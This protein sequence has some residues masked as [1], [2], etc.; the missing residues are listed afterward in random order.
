MNPDQLPPA[1]ARYVKD[2]A[3]CLV[4]TG[5]CCNGH[6]SRT[7]DGKT[8]LVRRELWEQVHGPIKPGH[9]IRCTCET[10]KCINIDCCEQTTYKKLGQ[11]L[12]A[13]GVMSG[14]VRSARIA[15]A[16]RAGPQAKLTDADV[17]RIRNGTETLETLARELHI[18]KGTAGRIRRRECRRDFSSPWA[19]LGAA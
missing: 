12:G 17:Q 7:V 2:D 6:P 13:L 10:P 9:I 14:P 11:Q 1:I 16:K 19:G 8:R 4:W 3:G 18:N 5:S 15:T